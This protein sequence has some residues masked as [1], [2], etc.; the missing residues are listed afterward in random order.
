MRGVREQP[1]VSAAVDVAELRW[2]RA[3][4]AWQAVLWAV[5]RDPQ[6][7]PT[8][9][10]TGTLRGFVFEGA[11]SIGMP[12]IEVIYRVEVDHVLIENAEFSDSKHAQAGRA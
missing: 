5:A 12:T 4:E 6:C 9:N 8:L 2:P 10:S 11:K 3:E 1:I 7:G